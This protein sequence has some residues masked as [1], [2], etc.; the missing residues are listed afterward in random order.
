VL[1]QVHEPTLDPRLTGEHRRGVP[2]EAADESSDRPAEAMD[3]AD[4]DPVEAG[5]RATI[6]F[7]VGLAQDATSLP[8]SARPNLRS[9]EE[10]GRKAP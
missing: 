3:R 1:L 6:R 8:W 10:W 9:F 4:A 2:I 7:H 5:E